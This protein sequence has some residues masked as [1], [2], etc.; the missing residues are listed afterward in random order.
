MAEPG[1]EVRSRLTPNP[2]RGWGSE[3]HTG[4]GWGHGVLDGRTGRVR[5]GEVKCQ[6]SQGLL[7]PGGSFLHN[8]PSPADTVRDLPRFRAPSTWLDL[9]LEGKR[10]DSAPSGTPLTTGY[11]LH[12]GKAQSFPFGFYPTCMGVHVTIVH[13][14]LAGAD[15]FHSQLLPWALLPVPGPSRRQG[16]RLNPSLPLPHTI[17]HHTPTGA[18]HRALALCLHR[19]LYPRSKP[20]MQTRNLSRTEA[21]RG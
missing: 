4:G 21:Q 10:T 9:N 13:G 7:T 18:W 1:L 15:R 16:D 8:N 14:L 19:L 12:V 20:V 11:L 3:R 17:V 6:R 2:R 5:S